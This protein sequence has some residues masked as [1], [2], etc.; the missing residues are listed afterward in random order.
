MTKDE[1][2]EALQGKL[3]CIYA[4]RDSATPGERC[5]N[6]AADTWGRD[7]ACM[8]RGKGRVCHIMDDV[9]RGTACSDSSCRFAC[10]EWYR[11]LLECRD[12]GEARK[13]LGKACT[14]WTPPATTNRIPGEA[15]P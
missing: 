2:G 10:G 11:K 4:Y 5:G 14:G 12:D 1:V 3:R 9:L 15:E 7:A 6:G 8:T 13:V